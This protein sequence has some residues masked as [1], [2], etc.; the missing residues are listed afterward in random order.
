MTILKK[1]AAILISGAIFFTFAGCG[2]TVTLSKKF[3][4]DAKCYSINQNIVGENNDYQLLVMLS[5]TIASS[6]NYLLDLC[7]NKVF[8]S[9]FDAERWDNKPKL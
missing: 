8:P 2:E 6:Y 1:L 3:D 5:R 4:S 7:E 9:R